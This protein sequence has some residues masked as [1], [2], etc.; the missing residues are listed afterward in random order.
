MSAKLF[1]K[2]N[3]PACTEV[4]SY[5]E[6]NGSNIEIVDLDKSGEMP[7]SNYVQI[8][9]ALFEGKKLMAYGADI[10]TYLNSSSKLARSA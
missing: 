6:N 1:I 2:E 3:C 10:I 7:G 5:L 4:R 8:V 9:P